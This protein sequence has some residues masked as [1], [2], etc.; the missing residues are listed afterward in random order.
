MKFVTLIL[1]FAAICFADSFVDTVHFCVSYKKNV[2]ELF[3]KKN[4]NQ[5]FP[6]LWHM[7]YYMD[8]NPHEWSRITY[9]NTFEIDFPKEW[10]CSPEFSP[11]RTYECANKKGDSLKSVLSPVIRLNED[12]SYKC[13]AASRK[14]IS[15]NYGKEWRMT[16]NVKLEQVLDTVRVQGKNCTYKRARNNEVNTSHL[17]S[18]I[19]DGECPTGMK[20]SQLQ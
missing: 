2:P 16:L 9:S 1:L 12:Y 15:E 18:A 14:L 8:C 3:F 4:V 7:D 5:E 19:L 17:F 11:S 20:P 13:L 6:R 10:G